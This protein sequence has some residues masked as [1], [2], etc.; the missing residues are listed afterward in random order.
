MIKHTSAPSSARSF[1]LGAVI[2]RLLGNSLLQRL[3]FCHIN[4]MALAAEKRVPQS[5][6]NASGFYSSDTN[7]LL[8]G[9]GLAVG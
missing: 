1:T 3:T 9:I 7:T 8:L 5:L 6:L 4:D 2:A